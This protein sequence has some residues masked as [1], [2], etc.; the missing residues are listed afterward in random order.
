MKKDIRIVFLGTP[1]FATASLQALLLAKY[2]IVGV[3]TA[4]DKPSG[5]GKKMSESDVKKFAI[6][7]GLKVL[8][9]VNL[10]DPEFIEE[11]R[12]LNANLGI[13]VAFRML[14]QVIW[15]MP[16]YGTFNL[17]ASLLPQYRG[18]API[19]HA[20]MNGE[21][22]TGVTTFYLKQKIDTGDII[23]QEKTH[24]GKDETVGEIH[25]RLMEIGSHLVV[26]TVE[27][28]KLG[29]PKLIK[30]S[31]LLDEKVVIKEAP[32]IFKDDCQIDWCK[33]IETIYNKIRGLSPYP[34]AYT[35]LKHPEGTIYY[36]KIY[37]SMVAIADSKYAAGTI[38][39]DNKSFLT[40]YCNGGSIDILD[41]QIAGKKR[42]IIK[43]FLNGFDMSD[44]WEIIQ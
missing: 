20:V 40:I 15:S 13:V 5:R 25:D 44:V 9:P 10:K 8:Q 27:A 21:T 36:M 2:N 41:L 34:A 14:P 18:A 32:K 6:K 42:M 37:K 33:P 24:I 17:H 30:Q 4:P 38:K 31:G 39:T 22:E 16:Q 1:E 3:I 11:F 28:I 43:D 23:F 7:Q 26:K 35:I 19:N 29:N 12:N